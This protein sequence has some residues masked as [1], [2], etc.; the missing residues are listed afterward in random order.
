M[1]TGDERGLGVACGNVQGGWYGLFVR[2]A[3]LGKGMRFG[4]LGLSET[5]DGW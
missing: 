5:A 3:D 1:G 4:E 2:W